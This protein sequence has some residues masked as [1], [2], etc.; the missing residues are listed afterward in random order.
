MLTDVIMTHTHLH[1]E[2][3]ELERKY[4]LEK[5]KEG[6]TEPDNTADEGG[7]AGVV[8]MVPRGRGTMK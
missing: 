5:V 3:A 6:K 8:V 1:R 4:A 2:R 7:D